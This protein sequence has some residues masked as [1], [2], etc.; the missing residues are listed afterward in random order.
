MLEGIQFLWLL[1]AP[2]ELKQCAQMRLKYMEVQ[3]S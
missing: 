1:G 3:S 2:A